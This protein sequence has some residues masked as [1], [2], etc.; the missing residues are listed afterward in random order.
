MY[1]TK[2]LCTTLY[3]S[4]SI[5]AVTSL[6]P[7]HCHYSVTDKPLLHGT[8]EFSVCMYIPQRGQLWNFGLM[9]EICLQIFKVVNLGSDTFGN[10]IFQRGSQNQS[11]SQIISVPG[12]LAYTVCQERFKQKVITQANDY[13][14]VKGDTLK[15]Q[16]CHESK[17]STLGF[18]RLL[19]SPRS[20][21]LETQNDENSK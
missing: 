1:T 18:L 20:N 15:V 17:S 7:S 8:R 9:G 6:S 4:D 2:Y 13:H 12:C 5:I 19:R 16:N 10:P 21:D 14:R 11:S 3:I